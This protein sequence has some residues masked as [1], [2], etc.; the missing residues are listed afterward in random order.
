MYIQ[1]K[2]YS[3]KTFISSSNLIDHNY[4]NNIYG[5]SQNPHTK[6]YYIIVIHNEYDFKIYC[7][8][9]DENY[10]FN[11]WCKPCQI[12]GLKSKTNWSSKN[13]KIGNI[14]QEMQLKIDNQTNLIYEWI[15]YNQFNDIKEIGKGGFATV[16][17]AI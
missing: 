17:S 3:I 5:I 1:A 14:M 10:K 6:D 16:Y 4:D 11:G 13:E 12:N 7:E 15:P 2:S 8:K 9:C